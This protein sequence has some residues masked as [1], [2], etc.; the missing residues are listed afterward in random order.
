MFD[1][2]VC[3][4]KLPMPE[5]PKGYS[6]SDDFQTKDFECLL[7][8]YEIREDG[9][10]WHE[11]VVYDWVPGNPEGKTLWE[12]VGHRTTISSEWKQ[13]T[14]NNIIRLFDYQIGRAH[15]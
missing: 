2:V 1:T 3:K 12:K 14:D 8:N 6:G 13:L 9:T 11:N 4:Y 10:I 7:D 5:D 15:V